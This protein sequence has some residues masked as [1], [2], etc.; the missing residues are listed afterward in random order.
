M[1][2]EETSCADSHADEDAIRQLKNVSSKC[3]YIK[4]DLTQ[5]NVHLRTNSY[6]LSR[7]RDILKLS[8]KCDAN[9]RMSD[10]DVSNKLIIINIKSGPGETVISDVQL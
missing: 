5:Q 3:D 9:S 10:S 8:T 6:K 1:F 2:V 4:I 7:N